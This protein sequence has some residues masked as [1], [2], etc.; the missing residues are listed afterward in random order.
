MGIFKK[1]ALKVILFFFICIHLFYS[2]NA[3]ADTNESPYIQRKN[4]DLIGH[5]GG[6]FQNIFI[7]GNKLYGATGSGLEIFDISDKDTPKLLGEIIL[8]EYTYDVYVSGNYAFIPGYYADLY[9]IDVSN[10]SLPICIGKYNTNRVASLSVS[11]NYIFIDNGNLDILDISNPSFPTQIGEYQTN[12]SICDV[13]ISGDYA[14]ITSDKYLEVI[15]ISN[16]I[17][18]EF[19]K[20]LDLSVLLSGIF[21]KDKYAYIYG[22]NELTIVDITNPISPTIVGNYNSSST[23]NI[24]DV[25]INGDYAYVAA[26]ELEIV[27][28]SIPA[29]PLLIGEYTSPN[30]HIYDVGIIEDRAYLVDGLLWILDIS[31]PSSPILRNSFGYCPWT[32]DV[33]ISGN[34]AYSAS[35]YFQIKD[36]SNPK[37]PKYIG[38]YDTTYSAQSIF[39]EG[40]YA[41]VGYSTGISE[42]HPGLNILNISN[43]ESPYYAGS[44]DTSSTV[45]G[46]FVS[47]DY[48]YI[49]AGDF[50]ILDISN[51]SSPTQIGSYDA[52]ST[53]L[54]VSGNYAYIVDGNILYDADSRFQIIDITNHSL[55]AFVGRYDNLRDA[56][57]VY[58]SGNYAYIAANDLVILDIT[59]PTS[60]QLAGTYDTFKAT[61]V[62][63][64]G[65]YAYITCF[66]NGLE[67]VD[68]SNPSSPELVGYYKTPFNGWDVICDG[69]NAYVANGPGGFYILSYSPDLILPIADI[70][71][72]VPYSGAEEITIYFNASNSTDNDDI[73]QYEWSWDGDDVYE[74]TSVLPYAKHSFPDNGSYSVKLRVCDYSDNTDTT[75]TV[76][77]IINSDPNADAGDDKQALKQEVINFIG[78]ASDVIADMDTL[79]YE[80][81]FDWDQNPVNFLADETTKNASH[82]YKDPGNYVV[83]LRVTDKDG[84]MGYDS[85]NIEVL[86][87]LV[88]EAY[89]PNVIK[90]YCGWTTPFVIQNL[91]S[92]DATIQARFINQDGGQDYSKTYTGVKN[93]SSVCINPANESTLGSSW[94]G[95]VVVYADQTV[96]SIVNEHSSKTSMAYEGID[97]ANAGTKAYLPNITRD[98]YGWMTPFIVQNL[99]S[100]DATINIKYY[101]KG[102]VIPTLEENVTGVSPGSSTSVNPSGKTSLGTFQGSVVV[103]STGKVGAV[104]NEHYGTSQA[105]SYNGFSSGSNKVYLPNITRKYYGWTTPFTIQNIGTENA[106]VTVKFYAKGSPVASYEETVT[107]LAPG[108]CSSLN[109]TNISLLGTFQGSVVVEALSSEIV[110]VVN[111]HA[112]TDS[113]AYSS[114]SGGAITSYLPNITKNYYGWTTPLIIKNLGSTSAL[115]NIDFNDSNGTIVHSIPSQSIQPGSSYSVNP[116]GQPALGTSFK[117]SLVVTCTNGQNITSIVNEHNTNGQAMSY[118]GL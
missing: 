32:W 73:K 26:G 103:E 8:P 35:G 106:T 12:Y 63:V 50:E 116:A 44:Y 46:I 29:Y 15:D 34:Y 72:G 94:K 77:N 113:M 104:V 40:D 118:N 48:A 11:G 107:G 87:H 30:Y 93:G 43:P 19:V 4:V 100:V 55:P 53:A 89:L 51:I 39:K 25:N 7:D 81:D 69:E 92:E 101:R 14:Y 112:L 5:L 1:R 68:I 56:V 59:N 111:E 96:A 42:N 41:F 91:S 65:N 60:P 78:N 88:P 9:I 86:N 24:S 108:S 27:D 75:S 61:G 109:P 57:D 99:D 2:N 79:T 71:A 67:I 37:M 3:F 70:S 38:S 95:S 6:I 36:I 20:R 31:I 10:P 21:I 85:L 45:G 64:S 76:V 23:T 16:P 22:S 13:E 82:A 47:G 114:I 17:Y 58:V 66:W 84:G 74:E 98:Y 102:E 105:M 80:W 117:G 115:V 97:P 28:I 49:A 33:N 62:Y 90:N 54:F 83:G 18:P 110:A 52:T